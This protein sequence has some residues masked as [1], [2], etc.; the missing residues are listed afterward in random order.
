MTDV[1]SEEKRKFPRIPKQ[2]PV[3]MTRV[4]FP[5]PAGPDGMGVGRDIGGG[6]ICFFFPE[7]VAEETTLSLKIDLKGW[8]SHKKPHSRVMDI[9]AEEPLTAIGK[10]AW[11]R[12]SQNDNGFDVGIEFVDIYEDDYKALLKYL[13]VKNE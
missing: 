9:A 4:T 5:L 3:E 7:R 6:G 12:R 13:E 8:A 2:A 10:V 1:D 11:C